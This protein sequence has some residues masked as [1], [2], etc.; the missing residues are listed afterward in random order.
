VP[1]ELHVP[2][3][4]LEDLQ[5]SGFLDQQGGNAERFI[6]KA[7]RKG[8]VRAHESANSTVI[9]H[10]GAKPFFE[11]IGEQGNRNRRWRQPYSIKI[12]LMGSDYVF[13][14]LGHQYLATETEKLDYFSGNLGIDRS[15][16][17]GA[18]TARKTAG[19]R[20]PDTSWTRFRSSSRAR[21]ARRMLWSVFAASKGRSQSHRASTLTCCSTEIRSLGWA[22]S[23]WCTSQR[24]SPCLRVRR[25]FCRPCAGVS[26]LVRTESPSIR[27]SR[28]G[29][30]IFTIVTCQSDGRRPRFDKRQL[31]QLSDELREFRGSKYEALYRH[32]QPQGEATVLNAM[33]LGGRLSGSLPTYLLTT[34]HRLFGDLWRMM[35]A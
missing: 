23:G 3:E 19:P 10:T 20:R 21:L 29:W 5:L 8:H 34:D 2:L 30:I 13:A 27:K 15:S 22:R 31:D 9:Y 17:L 11:A 32:G 24:M 6:E 12:K 4:S 1:T 28:D 7:I 25:G 18:S 35:P 26:G 16:C 33:G 14:Q